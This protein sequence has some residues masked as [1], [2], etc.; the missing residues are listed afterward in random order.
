MKFSKDKG[1][2]FIT[3]KSPG[4]VPKLKPNE[5]LLMPERNG[6]V[7]SDETR[8]IINRYSREWW[9]HKLDNDKNLKFCP[10]VTDVAEMGITI[11]LWADIRIRPTPDNSYM[12]AEF[13]LEQRDPN[14][15]AGKVEP[16][17]ISQTGVCPFTERRDKSV[18]N[19]NYLKLVSPWNV[20]TAKGYSVLLTSSLVNPRPEFDIVSGIINTDYYHTVNVVLNVLTDKPFYIAQGTPIAQMIVFKRKDNASK[21]LFGDEDLYQAHEGLGFGGP[22]VPSFARRGKYRREQRRWDR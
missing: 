14:G 8:P 2:S 1:I 18:Q 5:V 4:D 6:M 12:Q 16:F 22:W 13:N 10:G 11:P 9:T 3:G 7:Y 20:R 19:T 17:G 21:I 15:R